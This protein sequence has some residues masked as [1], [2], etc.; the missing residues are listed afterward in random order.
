VVDGWFTVG[1]GAKKMHRPFPS[2]IVGASF[3]P[4]VSNLVFRTVVVIFF[5]SVVIYVI[6]LFLHFLSLREVSFAPKTRHPSS[7]IV[8]A[9]LIDTIVDFIT[10]KTTR[11]RYPG[12]SSIAYFYHACTVKR[13]HVLNVEN[14]IKMLYRT[15]ISKKV[16]VLFPAQSDCYPMRCNVFTFC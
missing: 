6:V 14:K 15:I 5:S 4:D 1:S 13:V 8:R 10:Q 12:N 7:G 11:A 9:Q 2:A 3:R 16:F